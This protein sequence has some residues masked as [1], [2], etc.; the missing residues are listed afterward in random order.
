[1]KTE[2][3]DYLEVIRHL[4][5]PS[6]AQTERFAR[7]VSSAHSWYKHLPV[8]PKVPFVFYLDPGAGMKRVHTWTGE[9]ALIEITD[10]CTRFHFTWQKT[11]D[12]RRRFG[13]WNYHAPYGTA[14]EYAEDGGVINT[15]GVGLKILTEFGDWV[16]VPPDLAEKGTALLNAF[17]HP[18]PN[19]IWMKSP[20]RLGC[21]T[22]PDPDD[23]SQR[24]TLRRLC[25]VLRRLWYV[26]QTNHDVRANLSEVG[27]SIQ[28]I[29]R[30]QYA[31][32]QTRGASPD[33]SK[34][35]ELIPRQAMQLI[36]RTV[37]EHRE[38]M[39]FLPEEVCWD[40][41]E[42]SWLE[43][44][45]AL[46][47]EPSRLP[48]V[49]KYVEVKRALPTEKTNTLVSDIT[50][51]RVRQLAAMTDAMGRFVEAVFRS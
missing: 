8:D 47:V 51:E 26:P 21:T 28:L 25:H 40:W 48:A 24:T 46:G 41:P 15:A 37:A 42:E 39:D 19:L 22:I 34:V 2:T 1:M 3:Q 14:F 18:C 35:G 7:Y 27:G 17:V 9:T 33:F 13:Y 29:P 5:R 23:A 30:L 10:E 49:V 6:L 12:Y 50:N 31:L 43:Q 32:Q 44:L 36:Q 16:N 11:V 45:Q 38:S 4:P 20:P